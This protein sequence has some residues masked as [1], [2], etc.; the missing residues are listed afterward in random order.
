MGFI[1]YRVKALAAKLV[2]FDVPM[3]TVLMYHAVVDDVEN[4]FVSV[5][6]ADFAAQLQALRRAGRRFVT[7][8][9]VAAACRDGAA[10]PPDAVC[11]TFDDGNLDNLEVALPVLER[12]DIP[13]TIYVATALC[14]AEQNNGTM[15]SPAQIA[16]LARHP[17]ITI[18]GHGHR[19]VR[20][21][22]LSPEEAALDI[23]EGKRRLEDWCRVAPR[24]FAYP[25]GSNNPAVRE[26]V[27]EAGY[28]TAVTTRRGSCA[29]DSDPY[30]IGR[31]GV[32]R[33]TRPWMMSAVCGRRFLRFN[34]G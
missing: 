29:D 13:A 3:P 34:G 7:M 23:V 30:G 25:F 26:A 21:A 27:R 18:G 16:T 24:H 1:G 14:E 19:H 33:F 12:L 5:R 28:V 20:L 4:P 31:I 2:P 9:T 6:P 15:C 22:R 8:D 32:Y 10:L 11:V 17:L